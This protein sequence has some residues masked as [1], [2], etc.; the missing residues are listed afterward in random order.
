LGFF[1]RSGDQGAAGK[2]VGLAEQTAGSLMHGG[3][4]LL[5]KG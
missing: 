1:R 2:V 4:G 3:D 5:G